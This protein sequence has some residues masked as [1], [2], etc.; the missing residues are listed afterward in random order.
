MA[1]KKS[2]TKPTQPLPDSLPVCFEQEL[3]MAV[4]NMFKSAPE[5]KEVLAEELN[6]LKKQIA[7]THQTYVDKDLEE[8]TRQLNEAHQALELMSKDLNSL[9]TVVLRMAIAQYGN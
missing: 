6:N 8:R 5:F 4:D 7:V 1:T 3:D 9:K 2:I